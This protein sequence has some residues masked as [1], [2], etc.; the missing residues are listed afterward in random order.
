MLCPACDVILYE[1]VALKHF[2]REIYYFLKK[3]LT[4]IDA[5]EQYRGN[6]MRIMQLQP[7][8]KGDRPNEQ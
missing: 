6:R 3:H 7:I 8:S 4:V 1:R 5:V 2:I